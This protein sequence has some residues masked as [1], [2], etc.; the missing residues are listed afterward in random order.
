MEDRPKGQSRSSTVHSSEL[1]CLLRSGLICAGRPLLATSHVPLLFPRS[2]VLELSCMLRRLP[3]MNFL[4]VSDCRLH[5]ML[6]TSQ[7]LPRAPH[8]LHLHLT[9]YSPPTSHMHS[10]P[11]CL[12]LRSSCRPPRYLHVSHSF[13]THAVKKLTVYVAVHRSRY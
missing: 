4:V 2:L 7:H 1:K 3:E 10:S 9:H 12:F 6:T 5:P 11:S 8:H 13:M